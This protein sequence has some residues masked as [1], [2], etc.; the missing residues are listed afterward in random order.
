[1]NK[2]FNNSFLLLGFAKSHEE[3]YYRIGVASF[4]LKAVGLHCGR[5]RKKKRPLTL[6]HD[7]A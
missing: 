7:Q 6:S 3:G 4:Q 1:M 5:R 2:S